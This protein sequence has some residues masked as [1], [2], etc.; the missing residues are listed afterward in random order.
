[1]KYIMTPHGDST[2]VNVYEKVRLE[3]YVEMVIKLNKSIGY[4]HYKREDVTKEI[5]ELELNKCIKHGV[6][7]INDYNCIIIKANNKTNARKAISKMKKEDKEY[8]RL[9]KEFYN[10]AGYYHDWFI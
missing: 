9:R 2:Y 4:N 6:R 5:K 3:D 10:D 8:E 1:M 7:C